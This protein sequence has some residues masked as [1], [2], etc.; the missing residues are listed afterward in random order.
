MSTV[1][2]IG[3]I[4]TVVTTVT[5]LPQ[6]IRS[7]KT[8]STKDISLPSYI[9]LCVGASLWLMY[10]L[11]LSASPVVVANG[12]VLSLGAAMVVLKYKHG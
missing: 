3:Y 1:D 4:A 2:I 8:G 5:F 7:F 12:I 11:L 10:G 6:V 9:L